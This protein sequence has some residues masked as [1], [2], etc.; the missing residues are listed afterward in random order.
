MFV[1]LRLACA[2]RKAAT[3][4]RCDVSEATLPPRGL[5]MGEVNEADGDGGT[6]TSGPPNGETGLTCRKDLR[7]KE[8][9]ERL[10][11]A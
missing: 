5:G 10:L 7:L 11:R 2:S 3:E 1:E 8:S 4:I 9:E 6:P